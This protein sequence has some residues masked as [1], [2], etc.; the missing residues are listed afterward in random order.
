[1]RDSWR[2]TRGQPSK[3]AERFAAAEIDQDACEET[4]Y[5]ATGGLLAYAEQLPMGIKF[6][7]VQAR[8]GCVFLGGIDADSAACSERLR[9][10]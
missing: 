2:S 3:T 1:M 7:L 4:R 10:A 9:L 6:T 8:Y 5:V